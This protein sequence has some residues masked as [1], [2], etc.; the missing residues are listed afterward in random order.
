MMTDP[1]S[2]EQEQ[3]RAAAV[4]AADMGSA[5]AKVP[6]ERE[7]CRPAGQLTGLESSPDASPYRVVL[8]CSMRRVPD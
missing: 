4:A 5:T 2:R 6:T 7:L 3:R 1:E 8:K